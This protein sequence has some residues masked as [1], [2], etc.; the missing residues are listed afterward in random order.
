M[1]QSALLREQTRAKYQA[2]QAEI[3]AKHLKSHMDKFSA[4]YGVNMPGIDSLELLQTADAKT[5]IARLDTLA[6]KDEKF[7]TSC[8]DVNT[9]EHIAVWYK[10]LPLNHHLLANP[11]YKDLY[12]YAIFNQAIFA[13]NSELYSH[14]LDSGFRPS[15]AALIYATGTANADLIDLLMNVHK[16]KPN[17]NVL[18]IAAGQGNQD[19]VQQLILQYGM[20]PNEDVIN[21][22]KESGNE[23]FIK[24]LD[25]MMDGVESSSEESDD[26][27]SNVR[28]LSL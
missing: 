5:L 27:A 13:N 6:E 9:T 28:R 14:I 1:P 3:K 25:S 8:L 11:E 26:L 15:I 22:A 24:M 7:F 12:V 16:V 21:A 4:D 18:I 2:H 23:D 10:T 17:I 19:L 20:H